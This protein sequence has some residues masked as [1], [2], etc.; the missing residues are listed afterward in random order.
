MARPQSFP[1]VQWT[2][3]PAPALPIAL[4]A[5]LCARLDGAAR[6]RG[7]SAS[8]LAHRL[9]SAALDDDLI[10]AILDDGEDA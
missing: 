8:Q 9:L 7:V 10:D 3:R 4:E 2:V 1:T 6:R 5:G